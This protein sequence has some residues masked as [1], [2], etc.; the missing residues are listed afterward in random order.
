MAPSSRIPP[1][2]QPYIQLPSDDS[3]LLLTSTLSASAN[4]LL[5]RFLCNALSTTI[6]QEGGE[7]G[8]NVVVVS[9]M[10]EYDF[11]KQEARKG[12]GLDLERLRKE[13]RFAFVDGLGAGADVAVDA[14]P[15]AQPKSHV[16]IPNGT[17]A[18]RGPQTIPARGLPG[19]I[20][21]ARGPPAPAVEAA[22]AQSP[23]LPTPGHYALKTLDVA[24]IKATIS[25]AI[26]A[27]ATTSPKRKT[28]LIFDNPDL[29][30]ALNPSI[31][32]SSYTSLVL[33]L[34]TIPAVSHVL[35]HI[36]SDNPLLSLSIPPQPLELAH[37]NLL[38]KCAHMSRRTIGVRILDTGVARDVSGVIRVTEQKNEWLDLCLNGNENKDGDNSGSGK[39]FLY[40]VK[41]DGS[42]KVFERG[43][44]GEG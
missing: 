8:H 15:N 3:L 11:W 24:D 35:T 39:E 12:A 28:L 40:Q 17:Q 19:R 43:A 33:A 42:V 36:Q 16:A 4:W 23:T 13:G 41:G 6:A 29:L 9:W 18:Q 34:H 26:S 31:T 14:H 21:P 20:V 5:L 22:P 32:P 10:R 30:L 38:V 44:G 2:L 27:L 37:H 25:S 1:L 7:E